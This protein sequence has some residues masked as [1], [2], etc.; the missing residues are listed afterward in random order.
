LESV[1][2]GDIARADFGTLGVVEIRFT[3]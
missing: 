3:L 2:P 1:R